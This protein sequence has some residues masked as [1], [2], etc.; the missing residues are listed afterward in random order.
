M[1]ALG[2][3]KAQTAN[4]INIGEDGRML[5]NDDGIIH[6]DQVVVAIVGP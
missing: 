3:P 6:V 1:E 4:D 5:L 2:N